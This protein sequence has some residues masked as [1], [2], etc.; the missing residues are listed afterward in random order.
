MLLQLQAPMRSLRQ[1]ER[2][3]CRAAL[4]RTKEILGSPPHPSTPLHTQL[5][6]LCSQIIQ[7]EPLIS[8]NRRP[9]LRQLIGRLLEKQAEVQHHSFSLFKVGRRSCCQF[10]QPYGTW[11]EP[12]ERF[13]AGLL[14]VALQIANCTAVSPGMDSHAPPCGVPDSRWP[15][16]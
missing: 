2:K 8:E 16:S 14:S 10:E 7:Q 6:A 4:L 9:A 3:D 12:T 11:G 13:W 5:Q 1:S 15:N